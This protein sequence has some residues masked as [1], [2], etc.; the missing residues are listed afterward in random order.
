MVVPSIGYRSSGERE[1]QSSKRKGIHQPLLRVNGCLS[2]ISERR[3][4]LV[5]VSPSCAP[6]LRGA[7][8]K[9]E[10]L[11]TPLTYRSGCVDVHFQLPASGMAFELLDGPQNIRLKA[12][13]RHRGST[14]ST[15]LVS[16]LTPAPNCPDQAKEHQKVEV[17]QDEQDRPFM[18][19]IGVDGEVEEDE[20]DAHALGLIRIAGLSSLPPTHLLF[21]F[22]SVMRLYWPQVVYSFRASSTWGLRPMR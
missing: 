21:L 13:P 2:E 4:Y 7:G 1:I 10:N 5:V 18:L 9:G 3:S 11:V 14:I 17:N 16:R 22:G 15:G 6:A 8:E 19:S 20:E 12:H